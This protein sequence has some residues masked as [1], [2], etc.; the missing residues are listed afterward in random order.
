MVKNIMNDV[1]ERKRTLE[2]REKIRAK[3]KNEDTFFSK[4]ILRSSIGVHCLQLI[5]STTLASDDAHFVMFILIF[6]N[7][8]LLIV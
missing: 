6:L 2:Y 1:L 7:T 3:L 4:L 5:K 8:F